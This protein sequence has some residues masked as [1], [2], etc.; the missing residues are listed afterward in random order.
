MPAA[1][2][3]G[4][5]PV[6]EAVERLGRD[7]LD[8]DPALLFPTRELSARAVELAIAGED[9]KRAAFARRRGDKPDEEIVRVRRKDDRVRIAGAELARDMR[10]R[11]GPDLVHDL[12]PFAVGEARGVFPR[13]HMPVEA[14]VG[15]EVMAVRGEVQPLG[16]GAEAPAEQRFE[17]QAET[18]KLVLSD[19][20]SGKIRLSSV[21]R[22]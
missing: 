22:R 4:E 3:R 17:A 20:S 15:P 9:P 1:L 6:G 10:L 13:L 7:S 21:E 8:L 18:S 12:V 19:H 16:I 5:E 11:L 14:G 2:R